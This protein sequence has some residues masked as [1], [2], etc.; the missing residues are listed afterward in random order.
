M[1]GKAL[2]TAATAALLVA[3]GCGSGSKA[4]ALPQGAELYELDPARFVQRIDN[5]WWP[6]TPGTTW[7]Y[8]ET[9]PDG[10]VKR[11]VVTVT[12]DTKVIEGITATVV[13]DVVTEDGEVREDT[14]DWYAQDVDGNVWYLGEDTRELERGEVVSTEGS[15]EAGVDGAQ[16]GIAVPGTPEVGLAYRQE[17]YAGHAEDEATVLSLDELVEVPEG[18][19][20]GALLTRDTTPLDPEI[21]E[22]KLYAKGV[23]P[24]LAIGI[25]GGADRE[26]LVRLEP[27]S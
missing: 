9:E 6:M 16:A 15:W 1:H 7:T 11:V 5:P 21:S 25:S 2:G 3:A 27:S 23:G 22:H 12:D 19:Y 17:H 14:Y 18:S 20:T 10:T 26:E 13:H 24:V 8:R 4:T